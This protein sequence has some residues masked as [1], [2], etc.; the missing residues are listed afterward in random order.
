[1]ADIDHGQTTGQGVDDDLVDEAT[2]V[3]TGA[4]TML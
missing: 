2:T 1:M 3:H 4:S